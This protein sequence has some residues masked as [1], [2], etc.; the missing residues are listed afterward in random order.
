[1]YY[2]L[3]HITPENKELLGIS[4][5]KNCCLKVFP[6]IPFC[7]RPSEITGGNIK[8]DNLTR[9]LIEILKANK[10]IVNSTNKYSALTTQNKK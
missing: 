8:E 4:N 5:P 3:S 10:T 7:C 6:V 9:Q 1:M 2:I